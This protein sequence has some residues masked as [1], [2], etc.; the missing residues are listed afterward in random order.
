MIEMLQGF[1]EGRIRAAEAR[2]KVNTTP[3]TI[4]EFAKDFAKAYAAAT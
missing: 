4:E 3:T 2:S 1:N